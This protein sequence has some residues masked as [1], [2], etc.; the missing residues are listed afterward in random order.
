MILYTQTHDKLLG[1]DGNMMFLVILSHMLVSTH[2]TQA[3]AAQE[4]MGDFC[5]GYY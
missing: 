4:N 1:C 5:E 2:I 3:R